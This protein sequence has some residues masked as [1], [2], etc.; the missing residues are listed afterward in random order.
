MASHYA[1]AGGNKNRKRDVRTYS[2]LGGWND[3]RRSLFA[4]R[5]AR[6]RGANSE[7]FSVAEIFERDSWICGICFEP[8]DR[9][10]KHPDPMSVSLDH[11]T[12]L[13]LGG[14]HTRVNTR[15]AHLRCNV[16][17]GNRTK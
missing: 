11:I 1:K 7:K 4:E 16:V 14:A 17:R 15:C 9:D 2:E 6:K 12:P 10:L 3:R 8:V 13:S 5:E